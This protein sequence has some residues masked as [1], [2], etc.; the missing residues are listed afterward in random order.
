MTF[1]LSPLTGQL[2][3]R[4]GSRPISIIG[5][6]FCC[7]SLVLTSFVRKINL[8]FLTYSL[9]FGFGMVAKYVRRRKSLATG[10]VTAG[11]DFGIFALSP[12][13]Q[14]LIHKLGRSGAYRVLRYVM[15]AN[16]VL[17]LPY[18]PYVQ[19]EVA[20]NNS[21]ETLDIPEDS[22][23]PKCVEKDSNRCNSLIDCSVWKV[24]A[25]AVAAVCDAGVGTVTYT[26]QF[27]LVSA[28]SFHDS[29][30]KSHKSHGGSHG[31][32]LSG[33]LLHEATEGTASPPE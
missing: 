19:E 16:C 21:Q 9:L 20:H 15:L 24:P 17:S 7:L 31:R 8:F 22:S 14:L 23:E 13:S 1:S 27:H 25:F 5:G 33:F 6:F 29:K 30:V 2:C 18:D 11:A 10:I 3:E 28:H 12:L 26:A 32:S 4:F